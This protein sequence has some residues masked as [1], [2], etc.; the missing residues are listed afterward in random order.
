MFFG[1]RKMVMFGP[2]NIFLNNI[3]SQMQFNFQNFGSCLVFEF[4]LVIN[5][6]IH[7]NSRV[8]LIVL[9]DFERNC[10]FP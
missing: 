6:H 10:V 8:R 1:K 3:F 9:L 4:G 2:N 5:E 7:C